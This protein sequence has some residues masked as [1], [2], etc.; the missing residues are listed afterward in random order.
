MKKVI[1]ILVLVLACTICITMVAGCGNSKETESSKSAVADSS[2]ASKEQVVLKFTYKQGG[3]NDPLEKWLKEKKIL[4]N[5]EAS[6][7]GIKIELTPITSAEGDYT[8]KLALQLASE[9]T[10]PDIIMED[11]YMTNS[12]ASAGYL[13]CI[14]DY[15]N[16]W[17]DWEAY[18]DGTK[19]AVKAADGKTYGVPISTDSRGFW[20]VKANF[21]AAGIEVPWQ[22]K[23]WEDV[24]EAA[25]KIKASNPKIVPL[26]LTVGKSNGEAVTMQTFEQL[27][28][29]TGDIMFENGK[30]LV[31]SKGLLDTF[32]FVDTVYNKEKLGPDL[33]LALAADGT[34][35]LSQKMFPEGTIGMRLETSTASGNWLPTGAA[36]IAN[37]EDV[38]GYAAC[39]T[40][41]GGNPA[42]ISMT[43]GWSW[44]IPEYSQHKDEAW[45][46][47][48]FCGN[49]ENTA[50]RSLY[51]GRLAPR[52]DA[53]DI[54]EY[55]KRPF[56]KEMVGFLS[57]SYVRPKNDN[58]ALVSAQIQTIIEELATGNLTP[59]TAVEQYKINITKVVGAENTFEK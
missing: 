59:Q 25:R 26:A 16:E 38:I 40:Q 27:L 18:I 28:Y 24:L 34:T 55:S 52:K 51:D 39:P 11:T 15:V 57:N 4:E 45:K 54:A 47:I 5:F 3:S 22:P 1:R 13:A 53:T 8:S 42:T 12:D 41:F 29:G 14:D 56:I 50:W 10:A 44:A 31:N 33:S 43:G 7:P 2:S 32:T 21:K 35:I 6:N 46:F 58:Y 23:T 36:P 30:W 37:V 48:S 19:A 9:K 17:A 20:Y 49:K